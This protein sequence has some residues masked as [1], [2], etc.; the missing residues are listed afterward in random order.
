MQIVIR[1]THNMARAGCQPLLG[2]RLF[3]TN[4][5]GKR[6]DTLSNKFNFP[7]HTEL[8][9]DDYYQGDIDGTSMRDDPNPYQAD[10]KG[11]I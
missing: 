3:G 5:K 10:N 11:P 2:M 8:F 7:K 6:E 1:N 4:F 9:T